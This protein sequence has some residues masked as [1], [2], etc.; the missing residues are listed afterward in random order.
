[1]HQIVL[2]NGWLDGACMQVMADAADACCLTII[3]HC[4]SQRL[5]SQICKVI[6]SDKN[7]KLRQH[8]SAYLLQVSKSL[9]LNRYN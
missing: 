1:M 8:C 4:I 6:Q 3:Q 5:L 9:S 2:L 7:A